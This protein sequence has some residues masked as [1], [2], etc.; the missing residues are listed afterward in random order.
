M[1]FNVLT[2]RLRAGFYGLYT[3]FTAVAVF[4][5]LAFFVVAFSRFERNQTVVEPPLSAWSNARVLSEL[6]E[7]AQ[8]SACDNLVGGPGLTARFYVSEAEHRLIVVCTPTQ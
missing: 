8:V 3:F 7:A 2:P 6:G 5:V 4:S 1:N